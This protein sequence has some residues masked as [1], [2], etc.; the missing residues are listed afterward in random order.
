MRLREGLA[1]TVEH[2]QVQRSADPN[3]W[4]A[5]KDEPTPKKKLTLPNVAVP[6]R[7]FGSVVTPAFGVPVTN[8]SATQPMPRA[9][10]NLVANALPKPTGGNGVSKASPLPRRTASVGDAAADSAAAKSV[11]KPLPMPK[12]RE[13]E[14]LEVSD[15]NLVEDGKDDETKLDDGLEFEWAPVPAVP[16]MGR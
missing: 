15:A 5:P 7:R 3:A 14:V 10:S 2:Y 11:A 9:S 8:S 12:P 13:E 6:T 16:G 1:R 4:F